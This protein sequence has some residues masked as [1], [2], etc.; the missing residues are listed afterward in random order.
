VVR[1]GDPAEIK[2]YVY[3]T[4]RL[5]Y[6]MD[7]KSKQNFA[8]ILPKSTAGLSNPNLVH[9]ALGDFRSRSQ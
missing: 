9:Y 5:W 6:A 7:L 2:N 1:F 3:E 8:K 4:L